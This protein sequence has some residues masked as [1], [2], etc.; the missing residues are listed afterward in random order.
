MRSKAIVKPAPVKPRNKDKSKLN[1][2][3]NGDRQ[4]ALIE[5]AKSN[6]P[7]LNRLS[8][9]SLRETARFLGAAMAL[10]QP[11][12]ADGEPRAAGD[13]KTFMELCALQLRYLEAIAP[14]EAPRL[15]AIAMV[16][17]RQ[18]ATLDGAANRQGKDEAA[19]IAEAIDRKLQAH[20]YEQIAGEMKIKASR[21]VDLVHEGLAKLIRDPS[22]R[23]M[24]LDLQ[25]IDQMLT[26]VY[27]SAV[28][29]D[30]QAITSALALRRERDAL[31]KQFE[32]AESFRTLAPTEDEE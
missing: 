24:L 3:S 23:R 26:A 28:Q 9:T 17:S 22:D 19:L 27:P 7:T 1:N 8:L 21:A 2:P 16:H 5:A 31:E 12:G 6:L 18:R 10:K 25:R 11:W 14:H 32:R 13:Y 29:G 15:S 20:S 4:A 30:H